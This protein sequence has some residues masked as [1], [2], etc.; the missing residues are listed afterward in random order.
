MV[1]MTDG[2]YDDEGY[3]SWCEDNQDHILE[4]YVL[5]LEDGYDVDDLKA[6]VYLDNLT[7]KDVPEDFKL[8][9]FEEYLENGWESDDL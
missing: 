1:G 7:Y 3:E 4:Q 2:Y 8:E 6:Q 9:M 5:S